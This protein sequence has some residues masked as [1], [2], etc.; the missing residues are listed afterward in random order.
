MLIKRKL[1]MKFK[2]WFED[3][4]GKR[5]KKFKCSFNIFRE[6]HQN[7]LIN[8]YDAKYDACLK[9]WNVKDKDKN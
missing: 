5:P 4:F 9:A 7:D 1:K 6:Y 8:D 2:K 3:Q